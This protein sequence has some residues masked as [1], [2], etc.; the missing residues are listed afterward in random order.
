MPK[1]IKFKKKLLAITINKNDLKKSKGI[2]FFTN[3]KLAFQVASMK[4]PKGHNIIPH[5]HNK[6]LRRIYSTSEC[7]FV[8]KGLIKIN[9]YNKNN[10]IFKNIYLKKGEIIIFFGG[11]HGFEI[12]KSS[13]FI[14]FKQG[15]YIKKM[16][17]KLF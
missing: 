3:D 6:F 13:H 7:L 15:P 8:I 1:K 4:H 11:A 16:D 14:E 5:R 12:K 2:E 10:K 17:K 9:F